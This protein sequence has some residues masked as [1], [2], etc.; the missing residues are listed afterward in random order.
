MLD[1]M[2]ITISPQGQLTVPKSWRN[3][4]GIEKGNKIIAHLKKTQQG[5]A[6]ILSS[7]PENWTD[8]VGGSGPGLWPDANK[9]I[10]KER[11]SWE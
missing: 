9:Y 5:A 10:E 1:T 7:Q 8:L 6:I 11:F 2:H 4:L 3:L